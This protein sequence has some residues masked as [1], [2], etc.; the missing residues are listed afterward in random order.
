MQMKEYNTPVVVAL[1]VVDKQELA[2]PIKELGTTLN[3]EGFSF[4]ALKSEEDDA[5]IDS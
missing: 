2:R 3:L 1:A 5:S 4:R